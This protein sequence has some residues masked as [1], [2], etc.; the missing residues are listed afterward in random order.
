MLSHSILLY[1]ERVDR[2]MKKIY[3][4]KIISDIH[5]YGT[6]E[7]IIKVPIWWVAWIGGIKAANDSNT[8]NRAILGGA[9]LFFSLA[10]LMEFAEKKRKYFLGRIIHTLFCLACA[11]VLIGGVN[12]L[13]CANDLISSE[14]IYN[15]SFGILI[16]LTVDLVVNNFCGNTQNI[17][18]VEFKDISISE[19]YKS[20]LK[21][22]EEYGSSGNLGATQEEYK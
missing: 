4:R 16:F 18:E 12:L 8:G 11:A 7:S 2:V 17:E 5:F 22:F 20:R 21:T 15:C 9:F 13:F 3:Y 6:T 14:S 19:E 10:L 1:I